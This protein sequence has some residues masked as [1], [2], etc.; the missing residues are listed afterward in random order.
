VSAEGAWDLVPGAG[1]RM[2]FLVAFEGA[3]AEFDLSREAPLL[4]HT[5]EGSRAV[6]LPAISGYD[7]EVR[8]LVD[9]I[10]SG[11]P[12]R[13]T[14]EGAVAVAEILEAERRSLESGETVRL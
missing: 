6:A 11:G 13:A 1:F 9:A 2:R 14:L 4:V 10:G 12:L 5:A 7:G 8:H 3:T